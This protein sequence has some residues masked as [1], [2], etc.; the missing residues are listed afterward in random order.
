MKRTGPALIVCLLFASITLAQQ[1]P[2]DAP[3]SK[4]DIHRY[5][6]SMNVRELLKS[7]MD[8]M[9]T[10]VHK[11]IHEMVEKQ[12]GLP[13]DAEARIEKLT[14]SMFK[15]FPIDEYLDAVAPVYQKHFTKGD[16]D[17][18]VAFY[19]TP[20]GQKMLKEM[21]AI[22]SDAMQASMPIMQKMMAKAIQQAQDELAQLE[23]ENGGGS[24]KKPQEN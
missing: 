2:A 3:A 11:I 17:A 21:P 8:V 18:L 12:Q 19:S 24:T 14:D 22:M 13:P 4:E 15:D 10:Q 16:V 9:T 20:T 23:K 6:E 5:L 7:T 1:N